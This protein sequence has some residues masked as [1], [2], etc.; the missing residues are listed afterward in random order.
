MSISE[1]LK[2]NLSTFS[3]AQHK[4]RTLNSILAAPQY[5]HNV[6]N[7]YRKDEN[8]IGDFYCAPHLYF[9]ELKNK[10]L[11]IFDYKSSNPEVREHFIQ[12][13]NNNAL[14]IG[15]GG[16][17][18]RSSFK[19]QLKTFETLAKRGKKSVLWGI[20]HNDKNKSNFGKTVPY[21]IDTSAFGLVG[22]RDYNRAESFVPCVSCMHPIFDQHY[23]NS[24]EI[25]LVFHKNSIKNKSL[26]KTLSHYPYTCNTKDLDN[27]ISFI[28]ASE[29]V[30]TD[31]YHAM[32]WAM[33][34][35]K[36]IIVIPNSTKFFNFKY[37]PEFSTFN[38]FETRVK[39]APRYTGL[40]E[41]CRA[42]NIQFSNRVFNYLNL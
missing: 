3:R 2:R 35:E 27:M 6:V 33:L 40:L 25:G 5:E 42:L 30:V 7:I 26:L 38:E 41:E 15:G 31:S 1:F 8:N 34:L 11:D 19:Q 17:L 10:S 9:D 4:K 20:G 29:T 21:E 22:V 13:V 36:K 37:K 12:S 24:Q 14:I 16:L 39:K 23:S 32:Y 18:K 28:G